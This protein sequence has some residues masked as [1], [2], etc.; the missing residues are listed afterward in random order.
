MTTDQSKIKQYENELRDI[1]EKSAQFQSKLTS[2]DCNLEGIKD[3]ENQVLAKQSRLQQT[4]M[5]LR[6]TNGEPRFK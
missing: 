4:F 1:A 3:R 6:S 5:E 2:P